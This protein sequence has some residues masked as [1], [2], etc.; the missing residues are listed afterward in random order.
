MHKG[1][2]S[3]HRT[4]TRLK[5]LKII[6]DDTPARTCKVGAGRSQPDQTHALF[7]VC[8]NILAPERGR[9]RMKKRVDE[10]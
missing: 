4:E 10:P 8:E 1:S 9:L 3:A 6:F 7:R 5:T 2:R